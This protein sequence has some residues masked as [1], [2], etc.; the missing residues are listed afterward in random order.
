MTTWH[1]PARQFS[2]S[3]P[4]GRRASARASLALVWIF[5]AQGCTPTADRPTEA[6]ATPPSV[7][8]PSPTTAPTPTLAATSRPTT[9]QERIEAVVAAATPQVLESS[10]SPDGKWRAEVRAYDCVEV[11]PGEMYA[12]QELRLIPSGQEAGAAVDTQLIACGGLGAY[13]LAGRFWSPS[14]R[15]FYYTDA[16][17]GVPDGCG[18]WQPPLIRLD[19]TSNQAEPL[20][21]PALSLDGKLLAA[22]QGNQIGIWEVDGPRLALLD[23]PTTMTVTGPI[24][25]RPNGSAVA[26]LVT[27]GFCPLGASDLVRLDLADLRPILLLSYREPVFAGLIWDA[28]NRVTLTDEAGRRWR[29]NFLSR[30]LWPIDP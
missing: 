14:S 7:A 5:V 6:P 8:V 2:G 18:H 21:S 24:A 4:H 1:P 3:G 26:L 15:Y 29:Y 9:D 16:S 19:M 28:P 22:W 13:G 25:W 10:V 12:L 11:S 23:V 27:E 20:E 30:D 17:L